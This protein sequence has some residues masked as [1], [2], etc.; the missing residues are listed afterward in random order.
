M[1]FFY[2][3]TIGERFVL[4]LSSKA[5]EGLEINF[6]VSVLVVKEDFVEG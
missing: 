2:R 3:H 5:S 1:S 4:L 6:K